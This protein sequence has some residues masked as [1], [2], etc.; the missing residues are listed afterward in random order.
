MDTEEERARLLRIGLG[1]Y[2]NTG[3]ALCISIAAF[4]ASE[5][6]WFYGLIPIRSNMSYAQSTLLIITLFSGVLTFAWTFYIQFVNYLA[7]KTHTNAQVWEAWSRS[8]I[9]DETIKKESQEKFIKANF[10]ASQY[11]RSFGIKM[12]AL[13]YLVALNFLLAFIYVIKYLPPKYI[14]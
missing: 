8:P 11:D 12:M 1:A 3:V 10:K 14:F 13:I 5:I 2:R 9:A 7:I 4:E 6:W